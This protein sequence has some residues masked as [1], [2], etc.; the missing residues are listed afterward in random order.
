MFGSQGHWIEAAALPVRQTAG[1]VPSQ[2]CAD[3]RV[4][5]AVEARQWTV[6]ALRQNVSSVPV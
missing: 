2:W 4:S 6:S 3:R 5:T 1:G